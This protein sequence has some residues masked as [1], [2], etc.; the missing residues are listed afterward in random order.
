MISRK[1]LIPLLIV[2]LLVPTLRNMAL[3]ETESVYFTRHVD[4]LSKPH[5]YPIINIEPEEE[6]IVISNKYFGKRVQIDNLTLNISL[7]NTTFFPG[8]IRNLTITIENNGT[9]EEGPFSLYVRTPYF[10]VASEY[11]ILTNSTGNYTAPFEY[12][13]VNPIGNVS[14]G[15]TLTVYLPLEGIYGVEETDILS[16]VIYRGDESLSSADIEITMIPMFSIDAYLEEK[17]LNISAKN[18]T[19]IH[20]AIRNIF[21]IAEDISYIRNIS[22]NISSVPPSE[23]EPEHAVVLEIN[24]TAPPTNLTFRIEVDQV[25]AYE[26]LI[27]AR[28]ASAYLVNADKDIEFPGELAVR[29]I[30]IT[31]TQKLIIFDE[32]HEQYYRFASGYMQGVIGIA[33]KFGPVLINHGEFKAE[34]LNSE[35]TALV[36]IPNPQP[37]SEGQDIFTDDEVS[38]LQSFLES[39]GAIILMGNWYQYFW[40]S[41]K[42]NG[43]DAITGKYGVYWID[44][45]VYDNTSNFGRIYDIRVTNFA[46]NTIARLMTSGVGYVRFSGTAL[47]LTEPKASIPIEIYPILLGDNDT[48]V[49]LG[50]AT[51]PHVV[52]GTDVIMAVAAIINGSGRLF[53]CG[54]S[55]MFSDYYYFGDNTVFIENL[56]YWL[57]SAKKLDLVISTKPYVYVGGTHKVTVKITNR[58]VIAISDIVLVVAPQEGL[59][60]LNQ[61]TTFVKDLLEPGES[62]TICLAFKANKPGDFYVRFILSA[63]DYPEEISRT[64]FLRFKAGG[65]PLTYV[66]LGVIVVIVVAVALIFRWKKRATK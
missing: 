44:G 27:Y 64:V 51:E 35:I 12:V 54:S 65:I 37:P 18:Y 57:F 62:W 17:V 16:V 36:I 60:Y 41:A 24:N 14:P 7:E 58:G 21:P 19:T 48:F 13:T 2:L 33:S 43:Y 23:I 32:G 11:M 45:D 38:L 53:A 4:T 55:Y 50:A 25:G 46:N 47:N 52:N 28:A 10:L 42:Q 56:F 22:I 20:V 9:S 63:S 31:T 66:T 5:S 3:Q 39:G 49:T 30:L 34:I 40:P 1:I 59:T 61:T 15:D 26:I 29:K 6:N 8:I